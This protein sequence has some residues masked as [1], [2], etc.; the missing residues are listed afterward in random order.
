[1]TLS[2]WMSRSVR[3][4]IGWVEDSDMGVSKV[5]RVNRLL[6]PDQESFLP[7]NLLKSSTL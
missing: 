3:D 4:S 2:R 5:C 6:V 7:L 1:M